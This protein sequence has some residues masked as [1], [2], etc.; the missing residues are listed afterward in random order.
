MVKIIL[1]LALTI[2]LFANVNEGTHYRKTMQR[3]QPVSF[4]LLGKES[5]PFRDHQLQFDQPVALKARAL[6][7]QDSYS[8]FFIVQNLAE[9]EIKYRLHLPS[10]EVLS[11]FSRRWDR[12]QPLP[13]IIINSSGERIISFVQS[14]RLSVRNFSGELL[15]QRIL[16]TDPV[17]TYE[18]T[19]TLAL[20]AKN[21]AVTAAISQPSKEGDPRWETRLYTVSAQGALLK[22]RL[23]TNAKMLKMDV[24]RDGSRGVLTLVSSGN[25]NE[26]KRQIRTLI[27]DS[28]QNV[29]RETNFQ[30]RKALFVDTN[31]LLLM[32]K[33]KTHFINIKTGQVLW[34]LK[35]T[36]RIFDSVVLTK[37]NRV[38]LIS[39]RPEYVDGKL[40]YHDTHLYQ[41][42]CF[43]Y[44]IEKTV[45]PE[46]EFIPGNIRKTRKGKWK[47]GGRYGVYLVPG[48][49]GDK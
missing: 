6:L 45:I 7:I 8:G 20:N 41:T 27:L 10:G 26:K 44:E 15:W 17:F 30:F 9:G 47:L 25:R 29:L 46:A 11:E 21:G 40:F 43:K 2:S 28:T 36:E 1:F 32:G 35:E 37:K 19:Y 34:E 42:D 5:I 3:S 4:W 12:D 24:S 13:I 31:H 14:G 16:K 23:F 18:N 39:G 33:N 38:G 22:E 48:M 49:D